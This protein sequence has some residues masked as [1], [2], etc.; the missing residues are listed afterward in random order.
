MALRVLYV[1]GLES[2]V[3]GFKARY[4]AKH[5]KESFCAPMINSRKGLWY[6]HLQFAGPFAAVRP[7]LFANTHCREFCWESGYFME[8]I[9]FNNDEFANALIM[10]QCYRYICIKG[11]IHSLTLSQSYAGH[12]LHSKNVSTSRHDSRA[13]NLFLWQCLDL[14]SF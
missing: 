3:N 2:G 11:D 12:R 7:E 9:F 6:V 10:R 8:V 5:F 4:L 1:H 14:F 13:H